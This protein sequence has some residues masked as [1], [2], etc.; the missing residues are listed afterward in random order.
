MR[1]GPGP[2]QPLPGQ[3]IPADSSEPQQVIEPPA[4]DTDVDH[5]AAFDQVIERQTRK[6]SPRLPKV[7][8]GPAIRKERQTN[9]DVKV[10]RQ[11]APKRFLA[12]QLGL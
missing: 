1:P 6:N 4:I 5:F 11:E 8:T 3:P 7:G 9:L 10:F 2:Q 12:F